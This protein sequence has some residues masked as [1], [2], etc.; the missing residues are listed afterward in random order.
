M[1]VIHFPKRRIGSASTAGRQYFELILLIV[2]SFFSCGAETVSNEVKLIM[3]RNDYDS[4]RSGLESILEEHPNNPDILTN[5][6][7]VNLMMG[8]WT[9][10]D[11]ILKKA[12]EKVKKGSDPETIYVLNVTRSEIALKQNRFDEVLSAVS[13][14]LAANPEDPLG[15]R[16]NRA[17]ASFA[18][19]DTDSALTDYRTVWNSHRDIFRDIDFQAY[20]GLL[21]ENSRWDDALEA[22]YESFKRN[23][24]TLGT[25][26]LLSTL[27]EESG[28]I[29]LS[30]LTAYLDLRYSHAVGKV[31]S[32]EITA[33][34]QELKADLDDEPF[35]DALLAM[36]SGDWLTAYRILAD[37]N[38]ENPV[39]AYMGLS[40]GI[41]SG[42]AG[43]DGAG[44]MLLLESYFSSFPE[45]YYR[46]SRIMKK[47]PGEF[48]F[49]QQRPVLEK[50]I[51]LAPNS[52]MA[53]RSRKELCTL[54][55][56]DVNDS[57]DLYLLHEQAAAVRE[58]AEAGRVEALAP[59]LRL[60]D[61]EN[62]P[63]TRA[64]DSTLRNL[65]SI[66]PVKAY[67]SLHRGKTERRKE[68]IGLIIN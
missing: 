30:L 63:Y 26:V 60:L 6:A 8:D 5:L 11:R 18:L 35:L 29:P 41:E 59:L 22:A 12:M 43:L 10:A 67:L 36:E 34:L 3:E 61:F 64:A 42:L 62:N 37:E 4:I 39:W 25:G 28:D 38:I 20:T 15:S 13:A 50:V 2:L 23:G 45:Y 55:L 66:P 56:L 17:R 68:R 32:Q 57:D 24:Y 48:D 54:L 47:F 9:Q 44:A 19:K 7:A 49:N 46:L 52:E 58:F 40:A 51:L 16:L 21:M 14:A 27:H 53:D 31:S 1:P 33:N 65:V